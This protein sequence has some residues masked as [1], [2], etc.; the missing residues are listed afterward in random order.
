MGDEWVAI[1]TVVEEK[2]VRELIPRLKYAGA[3]GIIEF[4]LNKIIP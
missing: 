4:A 1:E 3:E 2:T